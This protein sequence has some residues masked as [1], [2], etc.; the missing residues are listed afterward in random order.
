MKLRHKKLK[1]KTLLI[2]VI[3]LVLG[4]SFFMIYHI[5]K[6]MNTK[7][8]IIVENKISKLSNDIIMAAFNDELI[9]N[10]DFSKIINLTKNKDDEIVALDFDLEKAYQ[11]SMNLTENI[12]FSLNSLASNTAIDDEI[13]KFSEDNALI[14]LLPLGLA[15]NN[16]YLAN[17]G[18]KIPVKV[19]FVGN[20]V[21]GL[22][23]KVKDYGINNSLIE[24]YI[25]VTLTEEIIVPFVKEKVNNSSQILL[26][27]QVINGKIPTLYN[28]YLEKNSSL[29]NV[30]LT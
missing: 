20:L 15:S 13:V 2:I 1:F 6:L 27:S 22:E 28:G 23:T 11:I 4:L 3:A 9:S 10:H 7:M 5:N 30:P 17:L 18:P 8:S 19:K 29:I 14:M 16:F 25:N 24:I 26:G 12:R 21:T